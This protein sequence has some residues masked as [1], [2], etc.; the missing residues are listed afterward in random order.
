MLGS[1]YL[2]FLVKKPEWFSEGIG[3]NLTDSLFTYDLV[4][5]ISEAKFDPEFDLVS[6]LDIQLLSGLD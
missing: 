5:E 3:Y 4:V 1:K 2:K 6:Y